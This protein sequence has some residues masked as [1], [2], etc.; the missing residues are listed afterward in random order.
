MTES[1]FFFTTMLQHFN[2]EQTR[3]ER[4]RENGKA[5]PA[6]Y[7]WAGKKLEYHLLFKNHYWALTMC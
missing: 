1:V 3:S 5:V 6:A 7:V 4:K 2:K